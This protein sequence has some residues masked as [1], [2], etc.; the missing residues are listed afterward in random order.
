MAA[1]YFTTPEVVITQPWNEI[2][3]RNLVQLETAIF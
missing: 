3:L 1:V 2:A